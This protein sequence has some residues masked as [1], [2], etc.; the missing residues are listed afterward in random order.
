MID[1]TAPI[2]LFAALLAF[3][4]ACAKKGPGRP[5]RV[6]PVDR[7]DG[8]IP[9]LHAA[10]VAADDAI[11]IDGR[12]DEPIWSRAGCTEGFVSTGDGRPVPESQV[13]GAA[14]FAWD[15]RFLYLAAV[16]EDPSADAP[17]NRDD[18]DP[19]IW[20]RSSGIEWM[21]QPGDPQDN[22]EYYE[23]QVDTAGAKWTTFFEDYNHPI[24]DTPT[25]RRFGH[26]EWEPAIETAS[27]IETDPPAYVIE[28]A[29]PWSDVRS[30]RAAVPPA[31]GDVWRANV[32]SFRDGQR[33]ALAW[34]PIRGEG[35][36]HK[37][38]RFGRIVFDGP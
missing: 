24:I 28:A 35:N 17:F 8:A 16:V 1:R 30:T 29:I 15:E 37:T 20:E 27:G 33:D 14:W 13:N 31:P 38:S 6:A 18:V 22:R 23:I 3:G 25:G 19:H 4:P 12:L 11:V 36:F 34:S 7:S 32:Y 5:P 9:V 10:R 21:L 26:Q 2:A